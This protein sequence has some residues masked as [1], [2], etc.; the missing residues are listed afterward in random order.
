MKQIRLESLKLASALA[1]E[2][3]D[4]F[5]KTADRISTY[6][7]TGITH[8]VTI[9]NNILTETKPKETTRGSKRKQ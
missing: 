8:N 6:I 5:F 7:E 1:H 2:S 3:V 9:V 4:E